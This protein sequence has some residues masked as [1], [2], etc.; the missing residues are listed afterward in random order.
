MGIF[1]GCILACDV[2]GTLIINGYINPRNIEKIEYFINEG[3][4][5]SLST[6]RSVKAVGHIL[7]S[8]K[9]ISPSVVANGCMIYDYD[10]ERILDEVCLPK[11]DYIIAKKVMDMGL[12]VGVE[13]HAKTDIIT[14]YT[15]TET[16]DHQKYELLTDKKLSFE[17]ACEYE[18]N[19]V[20]FLFD[21]CDDFEKVK[22]MISNEATCSSS[23][24][25]T[26]ATLY[27]RKRC[28]Y[29]QV[30]IGVSKSTALDKLCDILNIKEGCKF[31]MGDYYND[32][33]M[34]KKADVS[35][36]P[37]EAPDDIKAC[38]DFIAGTCEDGA[39]ADF[40]DYLSKLRK[41]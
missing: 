5:F 24:V 16:D 2:D 7:E 14:L 26:S 39:V 32:L 8:V 11:S 33:E 4:N 12:N 10:N 13:V 38:A 19:K 21:N 6:G 40:I 17:E 35:A 9:K 29:E 36:V 15:T 31:A 1:S 23:F 25:E 28:Y 41:D 20:I 34:L 3:G 18:W 30:P 37:I 27:G 22:C